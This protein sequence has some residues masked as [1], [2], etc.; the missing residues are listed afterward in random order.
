MMLSRSGRG[1]LVRC[2]AVAVRSFAATTSPFLC[3]SSSRRKRRVSSDQH[4]DSLLCHTASTTAPA[5]AA[6]PTQRTRPRSVLKRTS[7]L[8]QLRD[9]NDGESGTAELSKV[10]AGSA[11]VA[12]GTA[13]SLAAPVRYPAAAVS[14]PYISSSEFVSVPRPKQQQQVWSS[15]GTHST[16][17]AAPLSSPTASAQL[18]RQQ[19]A[20]RDAFTHARQYHNVRLAKDPGV[21]RAECRAFRQAHRGR[22]PT[23]QEVS[24]TVAVPLAPVAALKTLAHTDATR[25]SLHAATEAAVLLHS[26]VVKNEL[27]KSSTPQLVRCLRCF[28]VYIARPRTLWGGE[29]EQ[30]GIEYE[31]AQKAHRLQRPA[32]GKRAR[33]VGRRRRAHEEDPICCPKCRSPRAQWMMEYVHHHTHER[34]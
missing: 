5:P 31:K 20:L 30:S 23:Q 15:H 3:Y 29:V 33:S 13:A 18:E 25:S 24:R 19:Q 34:V 7:L 12:S 21:Y 6:V 17:A 28:H 2:V 16:A 8:E 4:R 22:S 10:P 9:R 1:S 32:P 11:L 27:V 26:A 14:L